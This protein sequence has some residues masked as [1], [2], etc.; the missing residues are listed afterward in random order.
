M[1]NFNFY[2]SV[3]DEIDNHVTTSQMKLIFNGN[4]KRINLDD[5]ANELES[6]NQ[7]IARASRLGDVVSDELRQKQVTLQQI[8]RSRNTTTF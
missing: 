2:C 1:K 7:E 6:V 4:N 8:Q 5:V 3:F